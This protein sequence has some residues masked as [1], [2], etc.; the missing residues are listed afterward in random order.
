M[1]REG[2]R[3]NLGYSAG[4]V[5]V[6]ACFVFVWS[7]DTTGRFVDG[8]RKQH[9]SCGRCRRYLQITYRGGQAAVT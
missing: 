4:I 6:A 5:D 8:Q 3:D 1:R 7:A 9:R 2:G